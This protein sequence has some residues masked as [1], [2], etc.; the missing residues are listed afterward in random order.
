M[1]L[2]KEIR[3]LNLDKCQQR[4][5][6]CALVRRTLIYREQVSSEE[7]EAIERVLQLARRY[8]YG[9]SSERELRIEVQKLKPFRG[10]EELL[11]ARKKRVRHPAEYVGSACEQNAWTNISEY[12]L[13]I[14]E[15]YRKESNL[16]VRRKR[17]E[18]EQ[19]AVAWEIKK[20]QAL[21]KKWREQWDK[22]RVLKK[23]PCR[24]CRA[25]HT[26]R[27]L[28]LEVRETSAGTYCAE[29]FEKLPACPVCGTEPTSHAEYSCVQCEMTE[30]LAACLASGGR[31]ASPTYRGWSIEYRG[32][33]SDN[34]TFQRSR[35]RKW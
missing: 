21:L 32:K 20:G 18:Q 2:I 26:V 16:K 6:A 23:E 3:E 5:F 29:C 34:G 9:R 25:W 19:L 33:G 12:A 4:L 11:R 10:N 22:A 7:K 14:A 15:E 31:H 13:D 35:R 17:E 27:A 30:E 8:A 28:A 24:G 1:E